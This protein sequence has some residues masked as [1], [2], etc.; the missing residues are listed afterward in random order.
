MTPQWHQRFF[1]QTRGELIGLLRRG[2]QTVDELAQP[3]GLTDN[4]VR[5]H[6]AALQRDGLVQRRGVRRG[7]GSGQPAHTYALTAEAERLFPKS[8][9]PLLG[10]LLDVL[11]E[12]MAPEEM[13]AL[14]REVGRRCARAWAVAD[15]DLRARLDLAVR[16]LNELGG[17]VELE[18]HDGSSVIQGRSCPFGIVVPGHPEMCRLTEA[19]VAELVG[20]PTAVQCDPSTPPRCRFEV[21][22]S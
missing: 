22:S 13:R 2:P 21:R 14:V 11:S 6:L 12:R 16:V 7:G 15:G 9:G 20:A 4:A 18:E 19:L 10:E 5:A 1:T 8:Y 17:L 3:L